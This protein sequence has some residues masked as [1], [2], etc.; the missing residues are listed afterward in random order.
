MAER[1]L[2]TVDIGYVHATVTLRGEAKLLAAE[3]ERLRVGGLVDRANL[4]VV[5]PRGRL[6]PTPETKRLPPIRD[7]EAEAAR[8]ELQTVENR[9]T[10]DQVTYVLDMIRRLEAITA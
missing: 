7:G 1:D 2:S 8:A 6:D 4:E 5:V 10:D 9:L 3:L